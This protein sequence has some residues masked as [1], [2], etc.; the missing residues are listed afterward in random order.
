MVVGDSETMKICFVAAH[1]D[2]VEIGCGG[3]VVKFIKEGNDIYYIALSIAEDSLPEGLPKDIL[4]T[5]AK[6]ATKILGIK[7]ENLFIYR[8]P[9]RKFPQFRQEIL[10]QLVRLNKKINPDLVF[11]PSIYDTHQDHHVIATEGFRAFK[12]ST[13]LGYE[14][15]SNN[16]TFEATAFIPLE[17][18]YVEKKIKAIKCYK[19][20]QLRKPSNPERI[21]SLAQ[22]RG[23][24]IR[25]DYAEAF[26]LV[27]WIMK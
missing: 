3:S 10:E 1:T 19:S 25:I 23:N 16:I 14:I 4:L 26:N 8:Y 7:A 12:A 21:K 17:K 2:D 5:E 6:L 20:Q 9:V 18:S 22:V 13:I 11:L 27:R 15:P 24:Q